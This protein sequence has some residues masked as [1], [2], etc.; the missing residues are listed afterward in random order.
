MSVAQP[1]RNVPSSKLQA[2]VLALELLRITCKNIKNIHMV[3]KSLRW[4]Y[5]KFMKSLAEDILVK[6]EQA[7]S[8]PLELA[9]EQR[10]LKQSEA[11]GLASALI[12]AI[13]LLYDERNFRYNA[14]EKWQSAALSTL[15]TIKGWMKS[16]QGRVKDAS[17]K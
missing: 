11:V 2:K 7:N 15:K 4:S 16:D 1:D 8:L 3:P 13:D 12:D 6:I 14:K 17:R 9:A 10:M 5:G